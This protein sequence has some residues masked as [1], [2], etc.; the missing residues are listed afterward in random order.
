M[1]KAG[2]SHSTSLSCLMLQAIPNEPATTRNTARTAADPLDRRPSETSSVRPA[3]GRR[4]AGWPT[5]RSAAGRRRDDPNRGKSAPSALTISASAATPLTAQPTRPTPSATA[6]SGTTS[7]PNGR[8]RA[9]KPKHQP[10][11]GAPDQGRAT[12]QPDAREHR[13][14]RQHRPERAVRIARELPRRTG[15]PRRAAPSASRRPAPPAAGPP[16]TGARRPARRAGRA[17]RSR[18]ARAA[19]CRPAPARP[20]R[21]ASPRVRVDL[22]PGRRCAV[23]GRRDVRGLRSPNGTRSGAQTLGIAA[24]TNRISGIVA[25]AAAR[26]RALRRAVTVGGRGAGTGA[27]S[28]DVGGSIARAGSQGALRVAARWAG[29]RR[30]LAGRRRHERRSAADR[31]VQC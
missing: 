15:W 19:V 17:A 14:R 6:P 27:A 18:R 28:T 4:A 23:L 5:G 26:S 21:A 16:G 31:N 9:S 25:S 22:T 3:A 12:D 24:T 1:T 29:D 30:E 20:A 8:L 7:R 10:E 2:C 13:R 11:D